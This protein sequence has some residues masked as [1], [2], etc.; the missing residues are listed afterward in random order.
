MGALRG[1]REGHRQVPLDDRRAREEGHRQVPLDDRRA[2]EDLEEPETQGRPEDFD[3]ILDCCLLWFTDPHSPSALLM[4]GAVNSMPAVPRDRS[5]QDLRL[6][7]DE[8]LRLSWA[9][10]LSDSCLAYGC[11]EHMFTHT[12]ILTPSSTVPIPR[13]TPTARTRL[14]R[15]PACA[16]SIANVD[17]TKMTT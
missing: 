1:R 9:Q 10:Q 4:A 13:T 6:L 16:P 3:L 11:M 5:K 15:S 7:P 17:A 8:S 2:R 14:C 12:H